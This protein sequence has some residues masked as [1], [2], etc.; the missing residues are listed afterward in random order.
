MI[1]IVD[2]AIVAASVPGPHRRTCPR[3][4]EGEIAQRRLPVLRLGLLRAASCVGLVLAFIE[5]CNVRRDRQAELGD[6][7]F[8]R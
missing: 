2:A 3:A 7:N 6:H 4:L 8:W 1:K 5:G